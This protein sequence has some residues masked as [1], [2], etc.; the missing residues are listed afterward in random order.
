MYA[1]TK[2]NKSSISVSS[3]LTKTINLAPPNLLLPLTGACLLQTLIVTQKWESKL[4]PT[5]RV[6][7]GYISL[8][9]IVKKNKIVVCL[10]LY[11]GHIWWHPL[12]LRIPPVPLHGFCHWPSRCHLDV[13]H[14]QLRKVSSR[15]LNTATRKKKTQFYSSWFCCCNSAFCCKSIYEF[16][17]ERFGSYRCRDVFL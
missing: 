17:L 2:R 10:F 3:P 7:F 6:I 4:K 14:F 9:L 1:Y 5:K 13:C 15:T 11:F 12:A 8:P 16:K